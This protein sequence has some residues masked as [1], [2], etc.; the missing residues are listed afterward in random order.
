M[1]HCSS[2]EGATV[3]AESR[4]E[5]RVWRLSWGVDKVWWSEKQD[6]R[7]QVVREMEGCMVLFFFFPLRRKCWWKRWAEV[8]GKKQHI[9]LISKSE[10]FFLYYYWDRNKAYYG[11]WCDFCHILTGFYFV[12]HNFIDLF[13]IPSNMHL[14][15]FGHRRKVLNYCCSMNTER[16]FHIITQGRHVRLSL[17]VNQTCPGLCLGTECA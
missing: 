11:E 12:W 3:S 10:E 13:F 7:N 4:I 9:F 17:L 2:S 15:L 5:R 6:E 14:T 8:R 16:E 1:C